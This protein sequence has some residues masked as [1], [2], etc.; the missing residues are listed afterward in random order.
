MTSSPSSAGGPAFA[1]HV[2]TFSGKLAAVG[3]RDAL[4]LIQQ[5][6]GEASDDVTS[7]TTILV[8]GDSAAREED[9]TKLRRAEQLNARTP[10]QIRII[11]E[12]EFCRLAGIVS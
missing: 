12:A 1:G 11:S 10:D 6:G 2:V 3:R 8:V 5:L 4:A 9:T 7:R